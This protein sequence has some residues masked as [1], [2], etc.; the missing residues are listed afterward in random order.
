[1]TGG[2]VILLWAESA[3]SGGRAPGH[4][5]DYMNGTYSGGVRVHWSG[6]TRIFVKL[7]SA[8]ENVCLRFK[9]MNKYGDSVYAVKTP[10][11]IHYRFVQFS[12]IEY[13]RC[14]PMNFVYGYSSLCNFTSLNGGFSWF[15][16]E[17][18][19]KGLN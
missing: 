14:S 17:P 7:A 13:T 9:A 6:Q 10:Y 11:D 12:S 8:K 16:G 18:T 3:P 2:D 4:V 5:T 15:C 19:K 1:M